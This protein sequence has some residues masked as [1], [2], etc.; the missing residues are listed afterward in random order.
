MAWFVVMT[1]PRAEELADTSLKLLGFRTFFPHFVEKLERKGQK[2]G[3]E[4]RRAYFPSYLFVESPDRFDTVAEAD[5]V[6]RVCCYRDWDGNS[7]PCAIPDRVMV[8]IMALADGK[9]VVRMSVPK[10]QAHQFGPRDKVRVEKEEAPLFGFIGEIKRLL[11]KGLA[12]V[13]LANVLLGKRTM[14]M[15]L[16]DLKKIA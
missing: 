5:G 15:Q 12:E 14:K 6:L 16:C 1:K 7:I 3:V 4:M 10:R 8:A 13:I 11:G 9:G 2:F